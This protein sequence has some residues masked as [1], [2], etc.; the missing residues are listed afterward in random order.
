MRGA[1]YSLLCDDSFNRGDV[2]TDIGLQRELYSKLTRSI[3]DA[4]N[5]E[6][7]IIGLI[8]KSLLGDI[9]QN[10]I[11]DDYVDNSVVDL[12]LNK[13]AL[14]RRKVLKEAIQKKQ[15]SKIFRDLSKNFGK[16][17]MKIPSLRNRMDYIYVDVNNIKLKL[18]L[19]NAKDKI[20][21]GKKYDYPVFFNIDENLS[22]SDLAGKIVQQYVDKTKQ[23]IERMK[24]KGE[25]ID[26]LC[27]I[28]KPYSASG[29]VTLMPLLVSELELPAVIYRSDYWDKGSQL[30][31]TKPTA[32]SR[33][34]IIYDIVIT[35]STLLE[36]D[37]YFRNNYGAKA[38]SAVV[39]LDYEKNT[40]EK[41][42]KEGIEL[43]S[44]LKYSDIKDKVESKLSIMQELRT[45][46]DTAYERSSEE[47]VDEIK[48]VFARHQ[49]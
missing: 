5:G 16:T 22:D 32:G 45:L 8:Y 43:I 3:Q 25:N 23:T 26:F 12:S 49:R 15:W 17:Y 41:L 27:F 18:F 40:T 34:C 1:V 24:K 7:F 39:F 46:G 19:N 4:K 44:C 31:G 9:L 38:N 42:A 33:L 11:E 29:A 28:E 48:R 20:Y 13:L 30:S 14:N 2:A 36:A 37:L 35:G 21:I 47:Q 10:C 6:E